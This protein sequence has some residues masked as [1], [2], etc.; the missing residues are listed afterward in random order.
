MPSL[1]DLKIKSLIQSI[2]MLVEVIM[3]GDTKEEIRINVLGPM[4]EDKLK[5]LRTLKP[6]LTCKDFEKM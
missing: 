4:Y 5:E 3:N 6:D 2:R 1:K